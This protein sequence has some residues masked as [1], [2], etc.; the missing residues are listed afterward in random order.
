M[1][2]MLKRTITLL[3]LLGL[4]SLNLSCKP[5]EGLNLIIGDS[6]S[7]QAA[8]PNGDPLDTAGWL[9]APGVTA[10]HAYIT[11]GVADQVNDP[12]RSPGVAVYAL[13]L[14]DAAMPEGWTTRDFDN[15]VRVL[16]TLDP[17]T[18]EVIV[19][20]GVG[21]VVQGQYRA[22]IEE[23]RVAMYLLGVSR[24]AELVDWQPIVDADPSLLRAD[25]IHLRDDPSGV[26]RSDPSAAATR[27]Q[28]YLNGVAQCG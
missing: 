4:L 16:N 20:P 8:E 24:G 3:P 23:A 9:A 10:D 2:A 15:M 26:R 12:A 21:A 1:G 27:R 7:W 28:L 25:G 6:V 14:N 22:E 11:Q 13:G 18:C 5:V 19:L 17:A